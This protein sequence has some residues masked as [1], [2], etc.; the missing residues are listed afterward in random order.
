[1]DRGVWWATVHG[2]AKSGR[3]LSDFHITFLK[4]GPCCSCSTIFQG[5]VPVP[6]TR[7][8]LL[9]RPGAMGTASFRLLLCL[10]L[11][12]HTIN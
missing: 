11:D 7:K 8:L 2:V 5:P 12:P 4:K 9:V 6:L 10:K 3:G 1:M